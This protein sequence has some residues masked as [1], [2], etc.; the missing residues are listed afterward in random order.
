[1]FT[2]EGPWGWVVHRGREHQAPGHGP[3]AM[4]VTVDTAGRVRLVTADELPAVRAAGGIVEAF[5]SYPALLVG[6]GELPAP[7]RAA[8]RGVDLAHRDARLALCRQADGRLLVALT[9][10][11]APGSDRLALPV[12]P[13]VPEMAALMRRLGCDRAVLLDGGLS[14]QL[15]VRDSTGAARRWPGLRSVPLGLVARPR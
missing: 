5:Q 3:L 13:T 6:D 15:L 4:A 11:D 8:G 10:L 12:G 2:D 7:L 14:G 9:R 1:M